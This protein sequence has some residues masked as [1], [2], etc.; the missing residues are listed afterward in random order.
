MD[1]KIVMGP[2]QLKISHD[3]KRH[4]HFYS[5]QRDGK[6]PV[7]PL[8]LEHSIFILKDKYFL[9]LYTALKYQVNR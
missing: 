6:H 5:L 8:V 7:L 9:V 3:S 1:L 2:F 4:H